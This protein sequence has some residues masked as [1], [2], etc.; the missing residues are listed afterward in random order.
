MNFEDLKV[1]ND[2][3]GLVRRVYNLVAENKRLRKDFPLVDQIKRCVISI[4]SNIAE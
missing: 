4:P 2:S 3:F 1:Y